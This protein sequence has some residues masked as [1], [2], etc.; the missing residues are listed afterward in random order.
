VAIS[1]I[2][3]LQGNHANQLIQS[4][5]YLFETPRAL[6][7]ML[8]SVRD[9]VMSDLQP[10]TR[11]AEL[12]EM[13]NQWNYEYYVLDQPSVSDAEYDEALN[14]LRGIEAEF[15][16]LVTPDS[17]TQRV[18]S[19]PQSAFRK[20][21]HPVPLLSLSNVFG[22]DEL[23]AWDARLRRLIGDVPE[24]VVEG[25]IDG[26]A[27]ALT[28]EMG[29][30]RH[31]ATRGDGSVGEDIT[32]NLKTIGTIPLR[33]R[34]TK[35]PDRIE[36]RGEVYMR[37]RDFN[38]LNERIVAS[39]GNAF[40]NPRNS[41][42]GSLRQLDP[43]MTA[44]R[45]LRFFAY[46]VG[47]IEGGTDL[48][49]H[50]QT[51]SF[52]ADAGFETSPDV[53]VVSDL[54]EVWASTQKWLDRRDSLDF[55]IDGSVVKVN[56]IRLQEEAGSV[57]REPRWA[58][59]YKFPAIQR[60]TKLLDIQIN[61]GRTGSLNPLAILEPVN[62]GGV[63]VR[64]A[65][66]HNEDEIE[67]KGLMIGDTVVVQRAG[68][69]IPQIVASLAEK[70]DGTE[71]PFAMPDECPA[72][73]AP[74]HREPG[75]AMRYCTNSVC[76]AQLREHLYHFVSRGAMDI[77]G[78]GSKLV[79]RFVDL[80]WVTNMASI[81]Y[82]NWDDIAGLEGLGEKSAE[83]LRNAVEAS[84]SRPF[85]RVIN[86]LGIRHV[87]ERTAELLANRFRTID[88]LMAADLAAVGSVP[89][90]GEVLAQSVVD[91]FA[92]ESNREQIELLRQA[93]V[94]LAESGGDDATERPLNGVT[95][96]LTG[97]LTEL[98]RPE[99]EEKLRRAGANVTGSVSKKTHIVIA[100]EDAGSKADKAR[101]LNIP[102]GTEQDM[103]RLL[104]G[105]R[106]IL[107]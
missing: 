67:R 106:S 57:G 85:A 6:D 65:T 40:M 25:K 54:N 94:T 30:L 63:V 74:V 47:Y 5:E 36:V 105:D 93:G 4:V 99:A 41:A 38:A 103:L 10:E 84:K 14:A 87:G 13:L 44:Q 62:I 33:L 68:D 70:R 75:E 66:L 88:A 11:A 60:T 101:E 80:G 91:F 31:G 1:D 28:Y 83:N 45:P 71:I 42:A 77:D 86:S 72:C 79:D 18:G 69:V 19:T 7:H 95:I 15:P 43:A 46:G 26:L 16:E 81:F 76:P 107:G 73:R 56:S 98:T 8:V 97:K 37:K 92:V 100:G 61:V 24:Y 2:W 51:L 90:I 50:S 82:L 48:P 29:L 52:L 58:T 53:V 35:I 27:V 96:V 21:T 34:G 102:I 64:R 59:A 32:S 9:Q 104:D 23:L 17:P 49:T 20:I 3:V 89:G 78:L 39:G 55:E 22:E 12:R